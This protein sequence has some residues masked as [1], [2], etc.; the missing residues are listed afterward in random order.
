MGALAPI[1]NL[2]KTIGV[3]MKGSLAVN[4]FNVPFN[5]QKY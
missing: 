1:H 3:K 5:L 2:I 4:N